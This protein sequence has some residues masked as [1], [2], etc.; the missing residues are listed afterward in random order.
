M[1]GYQ[2]IPPWLVIARGELGVR[3]YSAF[4][5][6]PK[7]ASSNPRIEEYQRAAQGRED[8][9]VPWCSS[10]VC[11]VMEQA[12]L[13]STNSGAAR[14]WM[15]WGVGIKEPRPGCVV[16]LWREAPTGY[17][18]HVGLYER[19]GSHPDSLV[20]LGGNQANAVR[21]AAFPSSR[22]LGYRWPS[23]EMLASMTLI[24]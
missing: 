19:R 22:V 10:F 7:G 4:R 15:R 1:E 9:D 2:V 18:G 3:E 13:P 14:S 6:G 20:L 12:G 8:D 11:W 24:H 17:K 5:P 16:V 23:P 21:T